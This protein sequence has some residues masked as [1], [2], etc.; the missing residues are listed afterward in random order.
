MDRD[1]FDRRR[2]D[3]ERFRWVAGA[4]AA[5]P[6]LSVYVLLHTPYLR[7]FL[8][9]SKLLSLFI[10]FFVPLGWLLGAMRA[11]ATWGRRHFGLQCSGCGASLVEHGPRQG[12]DRVV[13]R[14]CGT[15]ISASP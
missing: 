1:E 6:L 3:F 8:P 15:E 4:I 14:R 9:E 13:C 12:V 10:L 11:Y 2:A 5:A 7:A